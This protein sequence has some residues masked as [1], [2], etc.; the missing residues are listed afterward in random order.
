[1]AV[2]Q[3]PETL[4]PKWDILLKI[5]QQH[6]IPTA[7]KVMELFSIDF[8]TFVIFTFTE[9]EDLLP[10]SKSVKILNITLTLSTLFDIAVMRKD[11]IKAEINTII[12]DENENGPSVMCQQDI[13]HIPGSQ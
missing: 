7:V 11:D 1:M 9:D 3:A 12:I 13:H 6:Y 4:A 8:H 10:V 2:G 5:R